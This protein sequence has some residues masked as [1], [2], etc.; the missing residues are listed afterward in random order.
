MVK[1][2]SLIIALFFPILMAVGQILFSI[3]A[4]RLRSHAG[5]D[6]FVKTLINP[7]IVVAIILYA[8][9][10]IAWVWVLRTNQLSF[11][12]PISALSYLFVPLL[13]KFFL[14]ESISANTM[15]GVLFVILGVVVI[16][17]P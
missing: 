10:T 17:R 13:S 14:N 11:I 9:A 5:F 6:F 15:V 2:D 12:Y 3:G 1:I 16:Y 4:L 7:H 8:G